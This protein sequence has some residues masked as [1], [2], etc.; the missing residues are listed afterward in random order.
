MQA[1]A[2][3]A[4]YTGL[5]ARIEGFTPDDLARLLVDG[6]AVRMV[7]QR[8]TIHLVTAADALAL[9]PLVQPMLTRQLDTATDW[10][11]SLTGIDRDELAA[12]ARELY[13]AGPLTPGEIGRGLAG[14]WPDRPP[15]AL[16]HA[17]RNLLPL[18]QLPPRGIWGQGGQVRCLPA[19]QWLGRDLAGADP[20]EMVRR[21]LAAFG[22]A[23]VADAQV[24]S[25]VGGLAEVFERLRPVLATF[26]DE[27]GRELFDLPRAPR[28][29]AD[30]PA[31]V[32]LLPEFDNLLLSHADRRRVIGDDA[33]R[34][35]WTR[36]GVMPGTVLCDGEVRGSWRIETDRRSGRATL[37]ASPLDCFTKRETADISS[38][39]DR[40]LDFAAPG[41]D[42]VVRMG[43]PL[44]PAA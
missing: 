12:A 20:G 6:K 37:T 18:V 39:A 40:L 9:R 7:L 1:Q 44:S 32:R 34:T 11:P 31:P 35:L 22:P 42:H 15:A 29:P 2:P 26:R 28:P 19:E 16:A 24:W 41:S 36:N 33:R 5:R 17:A 38:E 23:T 13:A 4:P 30:T 43:S 27:D 25:G 14:R 21:Y 10:A 8:G 3:L